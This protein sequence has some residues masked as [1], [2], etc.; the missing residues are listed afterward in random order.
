[1]TAFSPT[2]FRAAA[3]ALITFSG[4]D[5]AG[6]STQI[7]NLEARLTNAGMR[8][9]RLALWDDVA[10]LKRFREDTMAKV[11]KGEKGIGSPEK[12]VRRNDKN[13]RRWY[14][15]VGRCALFS[16]DAIR[17]RRVIGALRGIDLD[18][19]I[20]DRYSYDELASLRLENRWVKM[21]ARGLLRVVPRPAIGF[22]L[23]A[24]PEIAHRRKPEYPVEFLYRYRSAY[25]FLAHTVTEMAAIEPGSPEQVSERIWEHVSKILEAPPV[26]Q[27]LANL[28]GT[29]EAHGL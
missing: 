9:I 20:F 10:V 27:T 13:V 29:G 15:T 19:I 28:L 14:L 17:L 25:L 2:R 21:F 26:H 23:D 5:G 1:M 24:E 3:P 7:A 4:I 22:V 8:F 16:L 18:I 6:K 11:F 12:P